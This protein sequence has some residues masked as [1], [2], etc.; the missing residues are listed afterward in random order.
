MLDGKVSAV[1]IGLR[2][3]SSSKGVSVRLSTVR[4][5]TRNIMA[6]QIWSRSW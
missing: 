2:L 6:I 3:I 5:S 1:R 4:S